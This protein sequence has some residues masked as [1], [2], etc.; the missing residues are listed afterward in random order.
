MG[1]EQAADRNPT[2]LVNKLIGPAAGPDYTTAVMTPR[3]AFAPC[4][5]FLQAAACAVCTLAAGLAPAEEP[6]L[7]TGLTLRPVTP[8]MGYAASPG[9]DAQATL[10]QAD[11]L[12]NSGL[13]ASGYRFVLLPADVLAGRDAQGVLRADP[14]RFPEGGR[15]MSMALRA[16][17]LVPGLVVNANTLANAAAPGAGADDQAAAP[18][19]LAA[20]RDADLTR[21]LRG[22]D[23]GLL[24]VDLS[25][26]DGPVAARFRPLASATRRIRPSAVLICNTGGY[27]G[28]WVINTADAWRVVGPPPPLAPPFQRITA[29]LDASHD[30]WRTTYP[31][32]TPDLGPLRFEGLTPAQR[33][34]HVVAWA[35]L[36]SPLWITGDLT[37]MGNDDLGLLVKPELV[38]M[39]Q[40]PL[41]QPARRLSVQGDLELWARPLGDGIHSGR[42]AVAAINRGDAP[43]TGTIDPAVLGLDPAVPFTAADLI[44]GRPVETG[45]DVTVAPHAT[46][47]LRYEGTAV[48]ESPFAR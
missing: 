3:F 2:G 47:L 46:V 14:A 16:R 19:G 32:C 6:T 12:R 23:V 15:A 17:D 39:H 8:V 13:A 35:M 21:L 37:Q 44:T 10:T 1:A 5:R 30:A 31:G 9:I 45:R 20:A 42:V 43:A 11:E 33:H 18:G 40:D 41:V 36:A 28:D 48:R 27:P 29:A 22:A 24:Q 4:A 26:A 25:E 38:A 34:T 7:P